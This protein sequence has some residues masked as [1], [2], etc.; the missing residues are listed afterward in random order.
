MGILDTH[1]HILPCMDDGARSPERSLQ[2]LQ[3]EIE[4]GVDTVV[5]SPHFYADREA[6]ERF[7]ERRMNAIRLLEKQLTALPNTPRL[8]VGAEVAY[9]DGLSR[10]E[11]LEGLCIGTTGAML[12]EMPFCP[13]TERMLADLFEVRSQRGIQPI[14]AHV[15]RY[16]SFQDR[17]IVSR[18]CDEG[19]WIQTNASFFSRWQTARK[20]IAMLRREEIHFIGSD[21]HDMHQ[22]KPNISEAA[23]KITRKLGP[24]GMD[25]LLEMKEMLLGGA[26]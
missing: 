22:R 14:V 25:F 4:Q 13:W 21:C 2:M 10:T 3:L 6:P 15:E 8:L 17:D 7:F 20:A 23:A 1:T 19:C 11:A 9:F 24:G 26:R 12:V 18:L 5:L 16:L